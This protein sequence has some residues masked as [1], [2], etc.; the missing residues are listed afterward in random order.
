M[1]LGRDF[2][3]LLY[4]GYLS[5]DDQRKLEAGEITVADMDATVQVPAKGDIAGQ[6]EEAKRQGLDH[7]E[8]DGAVPNPYLG[9][10]EEQKKKAK[11]AA[12]KSGITLSLHHPYTYVGGSVCAPY[13][14]DRKASVELHKK[15]L[16]FAA[17]IGCKNCI[18]HPGVVPFYHA[19]GKYYDMIRSSLVKSMIELG[20]LAS[21]KG[22]AFHLENNTAFDGAFFEPEDVCSVI[23]EVRQNGV[24]IYFNLDIGHWFTRADVGRPVPDPPEDVIKKI[25]DGMFKELHLNDYVPV[26]KLFHPPL[27]EEVG[28]LK[29]D[30]LIRYAQL[31]KEKG[32]ELIVVETAVKTKEQILRRN[33]IMRGENEF[34]RRILG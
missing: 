26:K 7:V 32:A 21:S 24:K 30:N 12:K 17:G 13:N 3:N 1:K 20:S 11:E 34:L 10:T 23:D 6:V 22:I 15:Y 8:L 18:I 27:Q 33:E 16:E 14:E 31:V 5:P 29:R 4:F 2:T 19:A 9:F 28:L 25:P